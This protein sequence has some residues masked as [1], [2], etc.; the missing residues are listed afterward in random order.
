MKTIKGPAIFL[1]QFA[2][3][4]APYNSLDTIADWVAVMGYKGIQ[5]PSWD[6]RL[7]DL[8]LAAESQTYC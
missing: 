6:A 5:I 4:A 2:G 8:T 7:F 3:D 1:A